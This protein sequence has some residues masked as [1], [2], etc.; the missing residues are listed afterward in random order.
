MQ[1]T[2]PLETGSARRNLVPLGSR[3]LPQGFR[4]L[5]IRDLG[6]RVGSRLQ[7]PKYIHSDFFVGSQ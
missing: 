3:F 1:A 5:G 6:Y 4:G 7:S 2:T